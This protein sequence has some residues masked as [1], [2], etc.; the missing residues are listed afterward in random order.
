MSPISNISTV[1]YKRHVL[2]S[3]QQLD[4]SNPD[5]SKLEHTKY[6]YCW[7]GVA[8]DPMIAQNKP[9]THNKYERPKKKRGCGETHMFPPKKLYFYSH[10]CV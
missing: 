8:P 5:N 6:K 9:S 7:E 2:L 4:Y 10:T 3:V 1:R